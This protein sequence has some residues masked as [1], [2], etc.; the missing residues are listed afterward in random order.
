MYLTQESLAEAQGLMEGALQ[1]WPQYSKER[2]GLGFARVIN[3]EMALAAARE[4]N[5]EGGPDPFKVLLQGVFPAR[6]TSS[7]PH[8]RET[9]VVVFLA[10]GSIFLQRSWL[11]FLGWDLRAHLSPQME[12]FNGPVPY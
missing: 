8:P 4:W 3:M 7:D 5:I 9:R 10:S 11:E 2:A 12:L 1:M 6:K